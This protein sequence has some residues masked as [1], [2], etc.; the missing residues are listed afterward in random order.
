[1]TVQNYKLKPPLVMEPDKRP[2]NQNEIQYTKTH[3][4]GEQIV[5]FHS[6]VFN[7]SNLRRAPVYVNRKNPGRSTRWEFS[8]I[9]WILLPSQWEFSTKNPH[10]NAGRT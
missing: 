7:T 10:R 4:Q 2:G 6:V 1:M 8:F 3:E 5:F 9:I